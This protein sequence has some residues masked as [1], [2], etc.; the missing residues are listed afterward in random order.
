MVI[1]TYYIRPDPLKRTM[2]KLKITKQGAF[3]ITSALLVSHF[4]FSFYNLLFKRQLFYA[5]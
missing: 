1:L 4:H 2:L 3:V 5:S